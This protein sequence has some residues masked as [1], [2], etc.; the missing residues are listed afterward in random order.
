MQSNA[1]K[2]CYQNNGGNKLQ[3]IIIKEETSF[4]NILVK[5]CLVE[6]NFTLFLL[7]LHVICINK[8]K[9]FVV[10][11]HIFKCSTDWFVLRPQL[12]RIAHLGPIQDNLTV[13]Q[14]DFE[15]GWRRG[16]YLQY[17]VM[18]FNYVN[19]MILRYR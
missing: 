16:N 18:A 9:M 1:S 5:V 7:K 17:H 13:T 8:S 2:C 15:Y 12:L 14:C 10:L 6:Y 19:M 11:Y 3:E 4:R